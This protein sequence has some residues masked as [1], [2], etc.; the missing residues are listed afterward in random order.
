MIIKDVIQGYFTLRFLKKKG[1]IE[2]D[3]LSFCNFIKLV[4]QAEQNMRKGVD[5]NEDK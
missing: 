1:F 4:F 5:N 2:D 3:K